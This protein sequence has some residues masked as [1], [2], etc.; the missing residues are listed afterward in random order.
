MVTAL[1]KEVKLAK[2]V[3]HY[4]NCP[5]DCAFQ[6]QDEG[7]NASRTWYNFVLAIPLCASKS[8]IDVK[9]YLTL[10]AR[11]SASGALP[12]RAL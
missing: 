7:L 6:Q 10:P 9:G 5:E 4:M 2:V 1:W 11:N 12:G 8:E 3:V